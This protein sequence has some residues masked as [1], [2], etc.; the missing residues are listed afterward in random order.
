MKEYK[1][2]VKVK[3]YESESATANAY[4]PQQQVEYAD[5]YIRRCFESLEYLTKKLEPVLFP[6]NEGVEGHG[7]E[8]ETRESDLV[9]SMQNLNSRLGLLLGKLN[10]LP[11]YIQL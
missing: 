1:D 7:K 5:D 2:F 10:L 4:T 8:E 3:S 11:S 9:M 6:I